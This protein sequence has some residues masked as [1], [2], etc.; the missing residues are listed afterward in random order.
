MLATPFTDAD[1]R[2]DAQAAAGG[3]SWAAAHEAQRAGDPVSACAHFRRAADEYAGA[4]RLVA[5]SS[6]PE[7]AGDLWR[8]QRD[9]WEWL[10]DLVPGERVAIPYEGTTLPAFFFRASGA[11]AGERRP[12]VVINRGC[13][14][15]T[16]AAWALG[17]AA[18]A[19]RGYHWL[20]FDGPGQQAALVEQGLTA[21]PDWEHVLTP[22]ADTVL[23]HA[24]VDPARLAVIGTGKAGLFVPRALAFEH[25]FAAAA[26]DPGIVDLG[27]PYRSQL[28]AG[29]LADLGAGDRGA[30]DRALHVDE[31]LT[32][33]LTVALDQHATPYGLNGCSRFDLFCAVADY[34]LGSELDG[35]RTP[36]LVVDR[37]GDD[38]WPG[39]SRDLF[40]R[41]PGAK[42][43]VRARESH[44]F[45]WLDAH[46]S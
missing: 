45:D 29:V 40:D 35:V 4:L 16:S 15:P 36:L 26:V 33:A 13:E 19:A 44:V 41:L 25:R 24:D 32:P 23:A 22:V 7:R 3:A 28:P 21:R 6:E 10:V 1:A 38:R 20:T 30:F 12:L 34:R 2:I 43:L 27:A 39:Q 18:A 5:F 8:R 46:L 14:E 11:A 37:D 17:G 42:R 31:L 9:C